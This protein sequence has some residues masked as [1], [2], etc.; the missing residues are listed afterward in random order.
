[1]LGLGGAAGGAGRFTPLAGGLLLRPAS[2]EGAGD[3][4]AGL[5]VNVQLL[6]LVLLTVETT[7]EAPLSIV[8]TIS[9]PIGD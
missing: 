1:M 3:T 7:G 8:V 6:P 2:F 4:T 5:L 9:V